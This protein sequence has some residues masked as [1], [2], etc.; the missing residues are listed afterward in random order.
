MMISQHTISL[1]RTL[2]LSVMM[3]VSVAS[4]AANNNVH[5]KQVT[6][7]IL[8]TS[9]VHG[10]FFP[11]D[12]IN[13]RTMNGSMARLATYVSSLRQQNPDGVI[14][15]ENGDIL[16][17]Q[18]IN[19][20]YNF[21]ATD[22]QNIASQI[23]NYMRYDAT[24][25]GNHDVEPGHD[26]FD[27]WDS[28]MKF[29][30]L[31]ANIIDEK[32]G[33]SYLK[34]YT[35]IERQGVRVAVIGMLTPA[36]PNWLTPDVWSGLRF[37]E[38]V[39][40]AHKWIDIV[41][42]TEKPDIIIGLLHS[43]L[44]GGIVTPEYE[45]NA[46]LHVAKEVPGFDIIM[47]GHDHMK[48]CTSVTSADGSV[49]RLINPSNNCRAVAEAVVTVCKKG[50]KLISKDIQARLVDLCEFTPDSAFMQ[51]FESE[52]NDVKQ[53]AERTIG[54]CDTTITTRDCFFGSSA[55]TDL[56][57]N[58]QMKLTGADISFSAP[59]TFNATLAKGGITVG[60]M[61]NL[62]KYENQL[63]TM[64][65]TGKEILGHLE[66]S[67]DLWVNTMQ[68]PDDNILQLNIRTS[69]DSH[70]TGFKNPTFNFDS[71][72]GIDYIV[73][74]TKPDGQKVKILR[75]SNGEPFSL[76]KTYKVAVN[77]YRANGG[78]ELLTKGAG[79][80]HDKLAERIVSRTSRDQRWYLMQEIERLGTISPRANNNWKF[81]PE[82]WAGPA[83]QR[84]RK[85]LFGDK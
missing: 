31:G 20:Y 69:G 22:R 1:V 33:Q 52:V 51:H 64:M 48:N 11:W 55:F 59:L 40:T 45:E 82:E 63:C 41:Q 62:Y 85:L 54:L 60:D 65:L 39:T 67:Y 15:L 9:D 36:I 75:M 26:V 49:V 7:N 68:S 16:Q 84:D 29:P 30:I 71:A 25:W 78:G 5:V 18:P 35:I 56:I 24:T 76:D 10:C 83:L 3:A 47:Y 72:A 12:F 14:L 73:D 61:F 79:I 58:L 66:M 80:P 21:I 81:V 44:D 34:P 57:H 42:K 43:G 13:K 70:R 53:W 38:M 50:K 37:E 19:Y 77:S 32:T 6:L 17:G 2:T 4:N 23:T 74:V 28:E 46:S 8:E 27:K